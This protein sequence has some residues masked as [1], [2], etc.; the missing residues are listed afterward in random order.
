MLSRESAEPG[1]KDP[2]HN[3]PKNV[4]DQADRCRGKKRELINNEHR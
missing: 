1:V 3:P 4:Q 2:T